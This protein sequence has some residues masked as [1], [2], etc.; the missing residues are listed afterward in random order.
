[1]INKKFAFLDIED[2]LHITKWEDTAKRCVKKIRDKDGNVLKIWPIVE[3]DFP[4]KDGYPINED[5]NNYTIYSETEERH[6]YDIPAE[7]VELYKK[8]K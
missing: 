6:G 2:I 4:A 7:L 8:V 5:G 3:T 1:M